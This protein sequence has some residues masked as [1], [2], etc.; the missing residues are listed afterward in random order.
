V[1]ST[2]VLAVAALL[3]LAGLFSA[4]AAPQPSPTRSVTMGACVR[5]WPTRLP[6]FSSSGAWRND[7]AELA[8]L[9]NTARTI[10]RYTPEGAALGEVS[11][12]IRPYLKRSFPLQMRSS[13]GGFVLQVDGNRF[14]QINGSLSQRRIPVANAASVSRTPVFDNYFQWTLV[15][16]NQG[17]DVVAIADVKLGER[18]WWSGV[19]RFPLAHPSDVELIQPIDDLERVFY[20]I[21]YPY[22]ATVGN[23][24][25]VLRMD[26][27]MGLYRVEKKNGK[28][29]LTLMHSFEEIYPHP[30]DSPRLP[31]FRQPDD[32]AVVMQRVERSRMPAGLYTGWNGDLYILSR[33]PQGAATRWS[34]SRIDPEGDEYLG[35]APLSSIQAN[36]LTLIPGPEKWAGLERGP[37]KGL[38]LQSVKDIVMIPTA[39]IERKALKGDLCQP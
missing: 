10:L 9:D 4:S 13:E 38:T 3:A 22:V 33:E 8:L 5:C 21:T 15:S 2:L 39:R 16:G 25:Y 17:E 24:A 1:R 6:A 14:E 31:M 12:A 28:S 11:P 29:S 32:F 36:H 37:V 18:K 35:T 7:G 23:A 19:V 26:N 27:Q 34:L 30:A 20:R